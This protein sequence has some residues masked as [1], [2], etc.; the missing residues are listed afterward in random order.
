MARNEQTG[1][2]TQQISMREGG[3]KIPTLFLSNPI[4]QSDKWLTAFNIAADIPIKLP[5][6]FRLFF[7]AATF[8]QCQK[9]EQ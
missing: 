2:M 1:W 9:T 3:F 7:D 5:L 8:C 6:K 4:G